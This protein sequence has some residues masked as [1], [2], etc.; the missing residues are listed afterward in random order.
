MFKGIIGIIALFLVLNILLGGVSVQYVINFWGT[1]L[2]NKPVHVPF[3]PCMIAGLFL[4]EISIPAAC[5][6]WVLSFIL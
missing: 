3:L 2:Q 5:L 6:T 4:G 1:Y